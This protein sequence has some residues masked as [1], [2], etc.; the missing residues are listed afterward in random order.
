MSVITLQL[1]PSYVNPASGHLNLPSQTEALN[2]V[3]ANRYIPYDSL[4]PALVSS[5]I[6]MTEAGGSEVD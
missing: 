2:E 4:S 6:Q 5:F 3:Y 1:G